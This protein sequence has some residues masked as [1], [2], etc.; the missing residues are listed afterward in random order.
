M[1]REALVLGGTGVIGSAVVRALQARGV[2]TSF[3]YLRNEAGAR[4]LGPGG[5]RVDLTK[6]EEIRTLFAARSPDVLIHCAA[7]HP[8]A[9][10]AELSADDFDAAVALSGRATVI[11]VQELAKKLIA[12]QRPGHV[13][14][15]GALERAQSLPLSAPFAAAQGM[16]GPLAMSFAKELGPHGILVNLVAGGLVGAGVS[17]DLDPEQTRAYEKLS[18]LR[19]LGKPEE[20][21]A[22]VVFLALENRYMTGKVLAAN[23]GI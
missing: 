17:Q 21:A 4:A 20:I 7:V 18:A 12:A 6:P 19:R 15:V 1:T 11:A 2:A 23:G 16:L 8:R 14:L 13:V 9:P 5:V 3:T 10:L 22:P